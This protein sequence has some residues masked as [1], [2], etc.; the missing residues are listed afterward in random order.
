MTCTPVTVLMP[1]R[2][3][4]DSV[5]RAVMSIVH[6]SYDT[7]ELL[8]VDDASTDG[9]WETVQ[10]LARRDSRVMAVR[11]PERCGLGGSL[12]RGWSQSRHELIGRM[13]GDDES[14]PARLARQVH[15]ME[16]H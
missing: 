11:N 10:A 5:E 7:W 8:V 14:F 15:F 6:Q 2:N 4:V 12:N 9:T 16:E 13:D 3:S 1:V